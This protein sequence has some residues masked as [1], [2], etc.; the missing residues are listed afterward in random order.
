MTRKRSRLE[1]IRD[2]LEVVKNRNGKIKPTQILSKSNLSYQMLE[3]Y[4]KELIEKDFLIEIRNKKNKTYAITE[5]GINYLI[6]FNLI[7]EFS[8][9]FGLTK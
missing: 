2:I 8:D 6:K 7:Q 9:S 1:I 4:L 5:K 3:A